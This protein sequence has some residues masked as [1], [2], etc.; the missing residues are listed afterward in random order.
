MNR[1]LKVT[2]MGRL[3]PDEYAAE[4]KV[5]LIV[6]LDNIR[7]GNNVGSVFRTADASRLEKVLLG[8]ISAQPPHRDILK[9][10]LGADKTVSWEY[11]ENM[12]ELLKKYQDEGWK[13]AIVEQMESST[14][15][16]DWKASDDKWIVVVG[17]EVKGVSDEVCALG[18]VFLEIP[19]FGTKHSLNVSVCTGMVV[20][21]FMRQTGL[22]QLNMD[23]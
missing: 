21:E 10:A 18:N 7:S 23:S 9:T 22:S 19:Q 2:E 14:M 6:G 13:I 4:K 8:G 5:Q 15:L 20:W 11:H 12:V 16:Q 3:S 1:K 17:N